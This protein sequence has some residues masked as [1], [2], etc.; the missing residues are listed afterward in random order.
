MISCQLLVA[1]AAKPFPA[2]FTVNEVFQVVL[3]LLALSH[4]S[5]WSYAACPV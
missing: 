2:D 3:F 1:Y 5:V 4:I